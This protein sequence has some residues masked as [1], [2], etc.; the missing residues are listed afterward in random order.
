MT[1]YEL[2]IMDDTA[3]TPYLSWGITDQIFEM[4]LG[5]SR[6]LVLFVWQ[7]IKNKD[8]MVVGAIFSPIA[9][10][11]K[12]ISQLHQSPP[13]SWRNQVNYRDGYSLQSMPLS[14]WLSSHVLLWWQPNYFFRNVVKLWVVHGIE[15][16][17]LLEPS[18]Y[19]CLSCW[20]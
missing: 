12:Y 16:Q 7:S 20:D 6:K 4:T 10:M 2:A 17:D 9:I 8:C 14:L 15:I 13:Q 1:P 5:N 18:R 11:E 3:P 19:N